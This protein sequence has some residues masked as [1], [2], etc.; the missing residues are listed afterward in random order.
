MPS[1]SMLPVVAMAIVL[2][3]VRAAFALI[4]PVVETL[5]TESPVNAPGDDSVPVVT[6]LIGNTTTSS[7]PSPRMVPVVDTAIVLL[8]LPNG[9]GALIVPVVASPM[10]ADPVIRPIVPL[11]NRCSTRQPLLDGCGDVADLEFRSY[12]GS[13]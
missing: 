10:T 13:R 2:P 1:G 5:I 12:A 6:T 11:R 9:A 8:L 7:S 4:V 3:P